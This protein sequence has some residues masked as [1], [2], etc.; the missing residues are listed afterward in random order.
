MKRL[1]TIP[2]LQLVPTGEIRLHEH[3]ERSR[4]LRLVDRLREEQRL[5]NPPIVARLTEH[6]HVLLDGANRVSALKELGYSHLPVQVI[7]YGDSEVLLKGWHHLLIEGRDLDL[8]SVY[9]KLPGVRVEEIPEE[10]LGYY[11][12]LRRV[13]AVFVDETARC[14]GLFPTADTVQLHVWI[15]T[16]EQ[17]VAAYEGRTQ[18]ERIKLADYEKLSD[19]FRA[20]DHQLVLFPKVSKVELLKLVQDGLM[21]PTGLTRHL[22]PG[23]ALGLNL[24]LALSLRARDGG[25]EGGTL[26]W[27]RGRARD[28]GPHPL[29]RGIRV[30]HERMRRRVSEWQLPT[31][32]SPS[33]T[34]STTWGIEYSRRSKQRARISPR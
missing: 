21:I 8:R 32:A 5:R 2:D 12:E 20:V 34:R 10:E 17:V 11:L 19:A 33:T 29:L 31:A 26:P 14:W 18:L 28:A 30:H 27:L 23:R 4:T 16:L 22:I 6:E 24:P 9:S 7:D 13:L 3:A 1:E 25:G 15:T